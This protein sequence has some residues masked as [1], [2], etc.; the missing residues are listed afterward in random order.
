MGVSIACFIISFLLPQEPFIRYGDPLSLVLFW[1]C[2][3]ACMRGG[4]AYMRVFKTSLGGRVLS[5][6]LD[7]LGVRT[8]LQ[9]SLKACRPSS[10]QFW[11]RRSARH[12]SWLS[13][14]IEFQAGA[15]IME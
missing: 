4:N 1:P 15:S 11:C 3:K 6:S 14:G 12:S 8:R 7:T 2:Q 13:L 10:L 5:R 9:L